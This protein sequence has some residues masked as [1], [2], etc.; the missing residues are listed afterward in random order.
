MLI[1]LNVCVCL[2][3]DSS[4]LCIVFQC[5][6]Q[7][8]NPLSGLDSKFD[9]G[10]DGELTTGRTRQRVNKICRK[11]G[12]KAM[13]FEKK[14]DLLIMTCKNQDLCNTTAT[15]QPSKRLLSVSEAAEYLGIAA[16]TIYN[17]VAPK[18]PNPFPVK[19]K[20]IGKKVL[21]DINDLAAFADSL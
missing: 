11:S 13:Y 17:A 21:F 10:F 12:H 15:V 4:V 2:Y 19:A 1:P 18:A 20:R 3:I 14:E 5:K 7:H 16:R 6:I 8:L 9:S